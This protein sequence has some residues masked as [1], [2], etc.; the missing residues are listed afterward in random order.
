[1]L[2]SPTQSEHFTLCESGHVKVP[3]ECPGFGFLGLSPAGHQTPAACNHRGFPPPACLGL[4]VLY[5]FSLWP[6]SQTL[7]IYLLNVVDRTNQAFSAFSLPQHFFFSSHPTSSPFYTSLFGYIF[8]KHQWQNF[9]ED[10]KKI[11]LL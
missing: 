4:L 9:A 11:S 3:T 10:N 6:H 7:V 2:K 1:M 5:D 8:F